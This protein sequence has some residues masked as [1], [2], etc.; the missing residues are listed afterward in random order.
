M[1]KTL[2]TS[3]CNL[4]HRYCISGIRIVISYSLGKRLIGY[5]PISPS[6]RFKPQ[7]LRNWGQ[8]FAQCVTW[9]KPFCFVLWILKRVV[10]NRNKVFHALLLAGLDIFPLT[11]QMQNKIDLKVFKLT[12]QHPSIFSVKILFHI[13][14]FDA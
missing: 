14:E 2:E 7:I 6:A 3:C 5:K 4:I 12:N 10:P 13:S 9:W 8:E 11:S 1:E